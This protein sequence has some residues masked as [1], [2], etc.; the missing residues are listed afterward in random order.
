MKKYGD[1]RT[2][3]RRRDLAEHRSRYHPTALTW[4]KA[5]ER[6]LPIAFNVRRYLFASP[7]RAHL[8]IAQ[9]FVDDEAEVGDDYCSSSEDEDRDIGACTLI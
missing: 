9:Q 2:S 7:Q 1:K 3:S 8:D 6:Y 4:L 5:E